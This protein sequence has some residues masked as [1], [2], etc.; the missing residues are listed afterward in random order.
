MVSL[1]TIAFCFVTSVDF[2]FAVEDE[3]KRNYQVDLKIAWTEDN[4]FWSNINRGGHWDLWS[5][6][7]ILIKKGGFKIDTIDIIKEEI[8]VFP[9]GTKGEGKHFKHSGYYYEDY[10]DH[11]KDPKNDERVCLSHINFGDCIIYQYYFRGTIDTISLSNN[12][13]IKLKIHEYNPF[14]ESDGVMMTYEDAVDLDCSYLGHKTYHYVESNYNEGKYPSI[15]LTFICL[16]DPSNGT[17]KDTDKD[18]IIDAEDNCPNITNPFQH[19]TDHDGKGD[20]CDKNL[21]LRNYVFDP[22]TEKEDIYDKIPAELKSDAGNPYYIIQYNDGE[23]DKVF[24]Y[25]ESLSDSVF[26]DYVTEDALLFKLPSNSLD[27]IKSYD[28]VRNAIL[29][30]PAF[31]LGGDIIAAF[32]NGDFVGDTSN[33]DTTLQFFSVLDDTT[34]TQIENLGATF[35]FTTESKKIASITIPKDKVLDLIKITG[36]KSVFMTFPTV[37][38]IG[39]AGEITKVH[40]PLESGAREQFMG[41]T[42]EGQTISI[43]DVGLSNGEACIDKTACNAV[44]DCGNALVPPMTVCF[45]SDI[46]GRIKEV[47]SLT[48]DRIRDASSEHGTHVVGI[49][50]GDGTNSNGDVKGVAPNAELYFLSIRNMVD[51]D[52]W[53]YID[54]EQRYEKNKDAVI[55]SDSFGRGNP[56]FSNSFIGPLNHMITQ[57]RSDTDK[58][59][60]NYLFS[61]PTKVAV[62]GAG[63]AGEHREYAAT[64]LS[65]GSAKNII[66]VGSTENTSIHLQSPRVDNKDH[67]AASSSFGPADVGYTNRIKP[68]VVAPGQD[69]FSL[70]PP[71]NISTDGYPSNPTEYRFM[72]GTSQA[73]PHVA[74]T[75]ALIR[76]HLEKNENLTNIRGDLLKAFLINGAVDI[77]QD[78]IL[79]T[80][81]NFNCKYNVDPVTKIVTNCT[82]RIT[83]HVPNYEQGWGRINIEESLKPCGDSKCIFFD[84][85]GMNKGFDGFEEISDSTSLNNSGDKKSYKFQFTEGQ[86]VNMTLAW[87]DDQGASLINNLDLV[88]KSPDGTTTWHGGVNGFHGDVTM[89]KRQE[90]YLY[91]LY[92]LS[93]GFN[94]PVLDKSDGFTQPCNSSTCEYRPDKVNN[95]EKM[96]VKIPKTG[97]YT[98]DV[99]A[100]KIFAKPFDFGYSLVVSGIGGVKITGVDIFQQILQFNATGLEPNKNYTPRI[101]MKTSDGS[102]VYDDVILTSILSNNDGAIINYSIYDMASMVGHNNWNPFVD[103]DITLS[104]EANNV[105]FESESFKIQD[106]KFTPRIRTSDNE[107][108]QHWLFPSTTESGDEDLLRSLMAEEDDSNQVTVSFSNPLEDNYYPSN[109]TD[110]KIWVLDFDE[111]ITWLSNIENLSNYTANIP[112]NPQLFTITENNTETTILEDYTDSMVETIGEK[113]VVLVQYPNSDGSFDDT[114]DPDRDDVIISKI[115]SLRYAEDD[116][117]ILVGN[118]GTENQM[119]EL[120]GLLNRVNNGNLNSTDTIFNDETSRILDEFLC[121]YDSGETLAGD[122]H[123]QFLDEINTV[124]FRIVPTVSDGI[125]RHGEIQPLPIAFTGNLHDLNLIDDHICMTSNDLYL[126]NTITIDGNSTLFSRTGTAQFYPDTAIMVSINNENTDNAFE[127]VSGFDLDEFLYGM[128]P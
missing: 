52:S 115:L 28:N 124:S 1:F 44:P 119:A 81:Q 114:F 110:T 93:P 92:F 16:D 78:V 97:L 3:V 88:L 67:L 80:T 125:D 31:K 70:R 117:S 38:N 20:T 66:T 79:G 111:D 21:F 123:T 19:D 86:T 55:F 34:K 59:A 113:F 61:N 7:D 40:G 57:Y 84:S 39:D 74:G 41:L 89:E 101:V 2:A 64:I 65:K 18:D 47:S 35:I 77:G 76:E 122:L 102:K 46:H 15:K 5:N 128:V 43:A 50:L 26:I 120:K 99:I 108:I 23:G 68:D 112:N 83:H 87:Y 51:L 73:T 69:I 85:T 94:V 53:P 24:N 8:M 42:G 126:N 14:P 54:T 10:P 33:I 100:E 127:I 37:L 91:I 82:D 95:V 98:L 118:N 13:S 6:P 56:N 4:P 96:I 45:N 90:D 75:L 29:Y 22:V 32:T 25:L 11:M 27:A 49:A 121:H 106:S 36:V 103:Y 62:V 63:N 9:T 104:I 72:G 60:D 48:T 58:I 109:G 105:V 116:L 71:R 30:E 107:S 17:K 12:V